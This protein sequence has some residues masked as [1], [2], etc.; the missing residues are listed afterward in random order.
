MDHLRVLLELFPWSLVAGVLIA[1]LCA[2]MGSYVILKRVVFIGVALSEAAALGIAAGMVVGFPGFA[3]AAVL[4]LISGLGLSRPYEV[5]RLPRDAILGIL[6]VTAAALSVLLVSGAGL[7]LEEVKALL[8]GDLILTRP[9]D[10][11]IV[12]L[13]FLPVTALW[14]LFHRPILFTFLDREAARLLGVRVVFWEAF[15]FCALALVV[16][17]SA[18]VAGALLVFAYLVV[19]PSTALL[20]SRRLATV[21]ALAVGIAIGCTLLGLYSALALDLPA[22]QLVVALLTLVFMVTIAV[23]ALPWRQQ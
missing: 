6:F 1:A 3:G 20:A 17:A 2:A 9:A 13:V 15:Y 18:R 4:T 23:R 12:A 22:N 7:G 19:A 5:G 16:A 21:L 8:Y 10:L 14:V 11:V